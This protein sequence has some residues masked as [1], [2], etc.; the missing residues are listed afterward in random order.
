MMELLKWLKDRG[1]ALAIVS[2]KPD[3]AVKELNRIYFD[4]LVETAVGE[5]EGIARKPAPD[6][7]LAALAELGRKKEE[8]VYVGDSEVDV[9][10]AANA[11][12]FCISVLW[13]FR[14]KELLVRCGAKNFAASPEDIKSFLD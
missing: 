12:I 3:S 14:D 9:A 8:A 4:G 5:K 6:T 13:G 11:G 2:N 10:T 7:V 1:Y